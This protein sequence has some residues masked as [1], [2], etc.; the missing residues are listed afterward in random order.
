M[1]RKWCYHI[2]IVLV[3]KNDSDRLRVEP[4]F[5]FFENRSGGGGGGGGGIWYRKYPDTW[6]LGLN[7]VI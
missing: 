2:S 3:G 5:F 4:Y 6:G 1:L 7:K